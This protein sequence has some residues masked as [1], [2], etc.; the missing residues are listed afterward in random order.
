M[1][2]AA[3]VEATLPQSEIRRVLFGQEIRTR[4][5]DFSAEV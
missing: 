5:N 1:M 2:T 4:V 3:E